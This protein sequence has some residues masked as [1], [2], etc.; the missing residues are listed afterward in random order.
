[1]EFLSK[2]E[3]KFNKTCENLAKIFKNAIEETEK[4]IGEPMDN[5][6]K[7]LCVL[8]GFVYLLNKVA[9]EQYKQP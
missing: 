3:E 7:K 1:M 2:W 8:F 6:T 9:Q 4:E 5:E